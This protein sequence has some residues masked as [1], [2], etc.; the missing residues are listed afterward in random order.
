MQHTKEKESKDLREYK[1][2][3]QQK[4][5][6]CIMLCLSLSIARYN[7]ILKKIKI[8]LEI[9]FKKIKKEMR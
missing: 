4:M 1:N 9:K 7:I 3:E 5:C 6:Q 2:L 8:T